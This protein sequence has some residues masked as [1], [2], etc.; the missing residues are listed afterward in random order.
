MCDGADWTT[1]GRLFQSRGPAAAK[2]RFKMN[3]FLVSLLLSVN[4]CVARKT[5][6]EIETEKQ[7]N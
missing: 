1:T 3:D 5:E 7:I 2:G 6:T 4:W